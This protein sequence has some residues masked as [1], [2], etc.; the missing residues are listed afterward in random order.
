MTLIA[1]KIE[2]TFWLGLLLKYL[3]LFYVL[4]MEV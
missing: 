1:L 2:E 3:L 4:G